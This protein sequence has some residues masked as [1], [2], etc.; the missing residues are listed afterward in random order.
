M[1]TIDIEL[2]T[3]ECSENGC[4]CE[5]SSY[6]PYNY[7]FEYGYKTYVARVYGCVSMY[8]KIK[9]FSSGHSEIVEAAVK[10]ILNKDINV[11]SYRGID[12]SFG[13][14]IPYEFKNRIG[15]DKTIEVVTRGGSRWDYFV[16][17]NIK[18]INPEV[19]KT[20]NELD[21]DSDKYMNLSFLAKRI[22]NQSEQ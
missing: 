2:H 22:K 12:N 13:L 8:H 4:K 5:D 16:I 1:S 6:Q 19:L 15:D 9:Y 3:R 18:D 17:H 11:I 10:G 21:Q 20:K 7:K 14:E